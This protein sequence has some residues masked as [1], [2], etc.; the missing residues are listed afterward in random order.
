MAPYQYFHL[1]CVVKWAILGSFNIFVASLIVFIAIEKK[2]KELLSNYNR[3]TSYISPYIFFGLYSLLHEFIYIYIYFKT[4]QRENSH[5]KR[6]CVKTKKSKE[7]IR[8]MKTIPSKIKL[9]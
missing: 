8:I 1:R 4:R 6:I 7:I 2:K 9:F 5:E 3:I